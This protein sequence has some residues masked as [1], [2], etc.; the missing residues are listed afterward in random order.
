M[1]RFSPD[2]QILA[3]RCE[4]GTVHLWDVPPAAAGGETAGYVALAVGAA[5]LASCLIIRSNPTLQM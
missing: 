2:G 3:V 4:D 5:F 1:A